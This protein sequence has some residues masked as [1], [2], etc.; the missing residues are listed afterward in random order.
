MENKKIIVQ[1]KIKCENKFYHIGITKKGKLMVLSADKKDK[2]ACSEFFE[3][4]RNYFKTQKIPKKWR[5]IFKHPY[6]VKQLSKKSERYLQNAGLR[7]I[8]ND[9]KADFKQ[10]IINKI[11]NL[12]CDAY[13][14]QW[15]EK[16]IARDANIK[17]LPY[18]SIYVAENKSDIKMYGTNFL[19][20]TIMI[21]ISLTINYNWYIAYKKGFAFLNN[22]LILEVIKKLDNNKYKVKAAKIHFAHNKGIIIEKEIL[23]VEKKEGKW[24]FEIDKKNKSSKENLILET[25][26]KCRG[27]MHRIGINKRGK[28][29]FFNHPKEEIK[30]MKILEAVSGVPDTTCSCYNFL[31]DYVTSVKSH[32]KKTQYFSKRTQVYKDIL[33]SE[34]FKKQII[35]NVIREYSAYEI[36]KA[37]NFKI[38]T[39]DKTHEK[40]YKTFHDFLK[41]NNAEKHNIIIEIANIDVPE[42]VYYTSNILNIDTDTN[43]YIKI[44]SHPNLIGDSRKYFL[45][46]YYSYRWHIIYKKFH[47]V[48]KEFFITGIQKE[49]DKNTYIIKGLYTGKN[50]ELI[51]TKAEAKNTENG[52]KIRIL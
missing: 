29:V 9:A 27:Q 35:K 14:R 15:I 31:K 40:I 20:R 19:F 1:W 10:R 45:K 28:I 38:Q 48:L 41:H 18:T 33:G 42:S 39:A 47:N 22:Y 24:S 25:T 50:K 34:Y 2:E 36:K 30:T 3:T 26:L 52:W 12:Q 23:V 37:S 21:S 6:I 49:I 7:K 11:W 13:I 46:I 4:Y 8:I 51:E 43:E 5:R 44:I 16:Q 17:I 32:D